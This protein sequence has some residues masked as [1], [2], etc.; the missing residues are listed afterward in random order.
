MLAL[1]AGLLGTGAPSAVAADGTGTPPPMPTVTVPGDRMALPRDAGIVAADGS[2]YLSAR[3][4]RHPSGTLTWIGDDGRQVENLPEARAFNGGHGLE[5][6]E[7]NSYR[8]RHYASGRTVRFDLP[9]GDTVTEVFAAGR[10]LTLRR[11]ATGNTLHLWEVPAGGG[12]P[13]DRPVGGV[14]A[15]MGP[16]VYTPASD[17]RGAA[18]WWKPVGGGAWRTA[19]LDFA[20]ARLTLVPSDGFGLLEYPR[21]TDDKVVFMAIDEK[22]D[23]SNAY[24]IDRNHPER[25]GTRITSLDGVTDWHTE[26]AVVGDWLVYMKPDD[27]YGHEVRAVPLSG[28]PARTLLDRSRGVFVTAADG[29]LLVEGGSDAAHWAVHRVTPGADGAPAT[30]PRVELPP[31]S[32]WEVGG[33]AV[34]QGRLLLAGEDTRSTEPYPGT[35]LFGS[36]LTLDPDGKLTATA[37]ADRGDLGYWVPG[38]DSGDP[39]SS[40]YYMTC[41][42]SCLRLTGTGEGTVAHQRH[43]VPEVVAASGPYTVVRQ[44]PTRQEVRNG[45]TVLRTTGAQAAA[46]WGSTLWTPGTTP[47]TVNAVSLPSFSP[48]GSLSTGAPCVPRELQV[49]GRWVYWSCG[50]GREAGVYDRTTRRALDVPRGYAQLADGYL[51][52]QDDAARKLLITYFPGAVPDDRTGTRELAALPFVPHAPQDRRGRHWAVDRFGGPVAHLDGNG[53]AV[54]VWP[55]VTTSPLAVIATNAPAKLNT[56]A[57]TGWKGAWHTSRPVSHWKLTLSRTG[58]STVLRTFTGGTARGRIA[59]SWD[60]TLNGVKAKP[61][62]YRWTLTAQPTDRTRP[63]VA[64]GVVTVHT[65]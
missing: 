25:P 57:N 2:G 54:V 4:A 49:V 14:P 32:R 17:A 34:D 15:D 23:V 7:G 31:L 21:L 42:G 52:S 33:F 43:D 19:L 35:R 58:E 29:S 16:A 11:S 61:G 39:G 47:G 3:E 46:L 30:A 10:L 1:G 38:D 59:V 44:H 20:S 53:D 27:A 12:A 55:R 18:F 26:M 36:D 51:V 63:V 22:F 40:G 45:D 37:P 56:S 5:H 50:P 13:V 24:V 9:A 6:I 8:V 60:G 41:Y 48:S 65:G 64:S 62:T 28:G